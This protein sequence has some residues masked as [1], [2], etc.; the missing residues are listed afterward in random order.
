MN[1][2]VLSPG[3]SLSEVE[4]ES[5]SDTLQRYIIQVNRI[6]M[7]TLEEEATL[8]RQAV[9]EQDHEAA[10]KVILSH[11]RLVVS[12]ARAQLGWGIPHG[13][14]IQEGNIALMKTMSL[15]DPEKGVRFATIA[16]VYIK[17]A[18]YDFVLNNWRLVKCVTTKP[19]KKLFWKLRQVQPDVGRIRINDMRALELAEQFDVPVADIRRMEERFS[20]V[21]HTIVYETDDDEHAPTIIMDP[22]ADPLLQLEN[23]IDEQKKDS[24]LTMLDTLGERD[25][26]ILTSRFLSEPPKTFI[27]LGD[28]LGI[29]YQRVDQ[30]EKLALK[31]L[32]AMQ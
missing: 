25:R 14:L 26:Y 28:I 15:F 12:M 24:I 2:L 13:D 19:L 31:K 7:L 23:K 18:M 21:E 4:A 10:H 27:E 11:L 29:S 32:R 8:T 5:T 20:V 30:L 17:N 6:P 3:W 22:H 9:Y 16:A 1:D